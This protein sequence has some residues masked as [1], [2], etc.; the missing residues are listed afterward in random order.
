MDHN[1]I[2]LHNTRNVP[3]FFLKGDLQISENEKRPSVSQ[4][5][6]K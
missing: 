3:H 4:L 5:K 2:D 6:T 1:D